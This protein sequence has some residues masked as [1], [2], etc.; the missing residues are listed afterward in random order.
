MRI[1]RPQ[2]KRVQVADTTS[3]PAPVLGWNAK[4]AISEMDPKSAIFLDNWFPT[5][6]DVRV[7]KGS[8]VHWTGAPA[9]VKSLMAYSAGSVRKLFAAAGAG[10]YDVTTPSGGWPAAAVSALT[11][12]EWQHTQFENNAG[13]HFL[14]CCNGVDNPKMFDGTTWTTPAITGMTSSAKIRAV[15]QFKNRLWFVE[16]GTLALWYLP[17]S[18]VTGAAAKV[19]IGA[20]A[21]FGGALRAV[22]ALPTTAGGTPDDY[23]AALTDQGEMFIFQGD[24]PAVAASWSLVGSFRVGRPI[25]WRC[26]SRLGDDVALLTDQGVISALSVVHSENGLG[27]AVSDGIRQAVSD[28]VAARETL[29]GWHVMV[30]SPD[31]Q[32]LLNLPM[33]TGETGQQYVMNTET[34]AWCR[35]VGWAAQCIEIQD[36]RTYI[37]TASGVLLVNTGKAD[38]GQ[39]IEADGSTGYDYFGK[40][41]RTKHFKMI[42]P[43]FI[44]DGSV[45]VSVSMGADFAAAPVVTSPPLT[46]AG[47][48]LWDVAT[49]DVDGWLDAPKPTR[50]WLA[51]GISGDCATT[52]VRVRTSAADIR[53]TSTDVLLEVGG[54]L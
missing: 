31:K 35:F 32:L 21:K 49:W 40:R 53:W 16:D 5:A 18:S 26:W 50:N 47:G 37:G 34:G 12:S 19:N 39:L 42:R 46:A 52:R 8:A 17:L 13:G 25:G 4:E 3:R 44:A 7:R 15:T 43:T 41:G 20:L 22:F 14:W 48:A 51:A 1:N 54:I 24:D 33:Q 27:K 36:G 11:N 38:Q 6:T 28:A 9:S 29:F 10:I 45:G 30:S 23:L 2:I